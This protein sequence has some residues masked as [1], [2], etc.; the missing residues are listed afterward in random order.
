MCYLDA[1]DTMQNEL[2]HDWTT[3]PAPAKRFQHSVLTQK[4]DIAGV[5]N[6]KPH[7]LLGGAARA[8]FSLQTTRTEGQKDKGKISS[9][10]R[11]AQ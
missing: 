11:K 10:C 6:N 2:I 1:L 7:W 9:S 5:R 4:G 3:A 8:D